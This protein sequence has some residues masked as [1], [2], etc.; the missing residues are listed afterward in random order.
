MLTN[1][2]PRVLTDT[3]CACG[4]TRRRDR[5]GR[6]AF[7]VGMDA[8]VPYI[9]SRDKCPL[10]D[11]FASD[12]DYAEGD[13]GHCID[14]DGRWHS[15]RVSHPDVPLLHEPYENDGRLWCV[16]G[17]SVMLVNGASAA[18]AWWA[19]TETL[20]EGMIEDALKVVFAE[21]EARDTGARA[22]EIR[23]KYLPGIKGSG[24]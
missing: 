10:C 21:R 19:H 17:W 2:L 12:H 3:R 1:T 7:H 23:A 14:C 16:C 11:T 8:V 4:S 5:L 18:V 15:H 24:S 13:E 6:T 20:R 22:D 9:D